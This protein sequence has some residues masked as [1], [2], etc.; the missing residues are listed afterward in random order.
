MNVL[1]VRFICL[2]GEGTVARVYVYMISRIG[3]DLRP[4]ERE[5]SVRPRLPLTVEAPNPPQANLQTLTR[6]EAY[7]GQT[8][9]YICS[10]TQVP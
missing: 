3:L 2:C 6:G 1:F 9:I 8:Y 10:G 5:H 4:A 7:I